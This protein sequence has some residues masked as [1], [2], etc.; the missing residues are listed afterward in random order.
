[1]YTP[2]STKLVQFVTDIKGWLAGL[3][4]DDCLCSKCG[5]KPTRRQWAGSLIC[6]HCGAIWND[7]DSKAIRGF[8]REANIMATEEG[9]CVDIPTSQALKTWEASGH[10]QRTDAKDSPNVY[11]IGA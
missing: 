8:M 9:V 7:E 6:G 10:G 4:A 11:R 2:P 5:T 3:I 1:M